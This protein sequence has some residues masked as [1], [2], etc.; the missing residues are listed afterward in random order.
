MAGD[1]SGIAWQNLTS[2]KVLALSANQV[3]GL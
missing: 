2:L 1:L 3:T